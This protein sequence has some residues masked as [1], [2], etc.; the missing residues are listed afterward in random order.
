M[1]IYRP[2]RRPTPSLERVKSQIDLIGNKLGEIEVR[3]S[4]KQVNIKPKLVPHNS[5]NSNIQHPSVKYT[6]RELNDI[7]NEEIGR[8][9]TVS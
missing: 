1:E 9:V 5:N 3:P 8:K 4:A 2:F 7:I 6:S